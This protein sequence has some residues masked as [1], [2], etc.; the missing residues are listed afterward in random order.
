MKNHL[1]LVLAVLALVAPLAMGASMSS[2]AMDALR[3]LRG[4]NLSNLYDDYYGFIDLALYLV[5]FVSLAQLSL[6]KHLEGRH[7]KM[8][9]VAVGLMLSVGLVLMELAMGFNIRSF[10]PVAAMIAIAGVGLVIYLALRK[11]N[12]HITT[13]ACASYILM[14]F[15]LQAVSPGFY[16]WIY[17]KAPW[18]SILLLFCMVVA[19]VQGIRSIWPSKAKLSSLTQ[20]RV[21]EGVTAQGRTREGLKEEART[22]KG[23][24]KLT[25]TQ[26]KD[27]KKMIKDL[28]RVKTL[29][30]TGRS[31]QEI[32]SM[33]QGLEFKD[34]ELVRHAYSM[35]QLTD[36][37]RSL[38]VAAYHKMREQ[39]Q[40]T[41]L[42]EQRNHLRK[43]IHDELDKLQAEG[44]IE[45]YEK[46]V[47]DRGLHARNYLKLAGTYLDSNEK[48]AAVTL[49]DKAID[50]MEQIQTASDRMRRLEKKIVHLLSHERDVAKA[51]TKLAKKAA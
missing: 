23:I 10:G 17:D 24:K 46:L 3:A 22:V 38:D 8:V 50:C 34:E 49:V 4:V 11:L 44:Q 33:L 43:E 41:Q 39:Y 29:I 32:T 2:D 48:G 21:P 19:V 27:T 30:K 28:E 14:Y 18:M 6:G 31:R 35:K 12:I 26:H 5:L 45:Q 16:D 15:S 36:R 13:A 9:A 47:E 1:I 7:G 42:K 25:K 51:E 40:G 20:R 37:L